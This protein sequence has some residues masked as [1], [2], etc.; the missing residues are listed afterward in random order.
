LS[1]TKAR[2]VA[3]ATSHSWLGQ[4]ANALALASHASQEA[5][6]ALSGLSRST[7]GVAENPPNI[8]VSKGQAT[9]LHEQL[10]GLVQRYRALVEIGKLQKAHIDSNAAGLDRPLVDRLGEYPAEGVNL[11]N[12]VTYPPKLEM[13]PVK[14][15]FLDVAWNYIAYPSQDG[16][17]KSKG[18][19]A[20]KP[21]AEAAVDDKQPQKRGWFGFGR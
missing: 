2:C 4:Q 3:L 5:E 20:T 1:L 21:N 7:H 6:A 16:A 17:D 15:L 10:Q 8:G 12:I 18:R 13:I 19:L 14:P 9:F 11:D